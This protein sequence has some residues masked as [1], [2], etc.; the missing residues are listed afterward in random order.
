MTIGL[1]YGEILALNK[2]LNKNGL[3]LGVEQWKLC[4]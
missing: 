4:T 1:I 3:R 2:E